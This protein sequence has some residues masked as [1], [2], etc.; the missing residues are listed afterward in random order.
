MQT[1]PSIGAGD[2]SSQ[3]S[4]LASRG[5]VLTARR[6][7]DCAVLAAGRFGYC[8]T[9]PGDKEIVS[10]PAV[11]FADD[12]EWYTGTAGLTGSGKW[13]NYYQ[14]SNTRIA[15]GT[16]SVYAGAKALEFT[17]PQTN[18]EVANAVVRNL[19]VKRD[20]LFVRV[21]TKFEVGFDGTTEGHNG[22]RISGIIRGPERF[23]NGQ[24]FF[25]YTVENSVYYG[26][27]YPGPITCMPTT[28]S[29]AASG[30]TTS[31]RPAKVLPIDSRR[32]T[33]GRPS[34]HARISRHR[35]TV[36]IRTR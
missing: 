14:A 7:R 35:P 6:D 11:I 25:L 36:G 17:M 10:D 27:A 16:G 13:S 22:I 18:S 19:P 24:D 2:D 34:W 29:S 23:Q 32:G 15:T 1:D 3:D 12:F 20:V 8:L 30:A 28:Q 33:S 4:R 9:L 31:T 21:Y 5:R 26:E